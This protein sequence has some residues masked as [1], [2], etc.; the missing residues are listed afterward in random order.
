MK[1]RRNVIRLANS[2]RYKALLPPVDQHFKL[3]WALS[4]QYGTRSLTN[5]SARWPLTPVPVGSTYTDRPSGQHVV[6]LAKKTLKLRVLQTVDEIYSYRFMV[7]EQQRGEEITD[8]TVTCPVPNQVLSLNSSVDPGSFM[9][10]PYLLSEQKDDTLGAIVKYDKVYTLDSRTKCNSVLIK[11]RIPSTKVEYESGSLTGNFHVYGAQWL[12][13]MTN[14]P[15][16][17]AT[18]TISFNANRKFV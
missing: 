12:V 15:A 6:R 9:L 7:L 8:V 3:L 16:S 5:W 17:T 18:C 10:A 4:S 13:V 11:V 14:A 1:K 2:Y